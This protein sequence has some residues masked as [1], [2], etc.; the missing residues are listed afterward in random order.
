MNCHSSTLIDKPSGNRSA[1][2][3]MNMP[4]E[5]WQLI[6]Y[7]AVMAL[8]MFLVQYFI[9]SNVMLY[10]WSHIHN[11][12]NKIFMALLMAMLM[13]VIEISVAIALAQGKINLPLALFL[14]TIG[15][16]GTAVVIGFI[17][18][19]TLIDDRNFVLSMEE[20]HSN[21]LL[22]ADRILQRTHDPEI[23]QVA[24]NIYRSQTDEIAF[25]ERWLKTH[26]K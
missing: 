11:N 6:V 4:T 13:V 14:G 1:H 20:H 16:V 24:E 17:R 10:S 23:R 8:L 12:W 18:K 26:K 22:M 15:V 21:A 9:A 19:Q 3:G 25:F 2:G 5:G 7:I